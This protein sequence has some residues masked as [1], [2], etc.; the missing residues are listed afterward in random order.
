VE[1]FTLAVCNDP[2][3]VRVVLHQVVLEQDFPRNVQD[4]LN[5]IMQNTVEEALAQALPPGIAF[6]RA[7]EKSGGM[8]AA[9]DEHLDGSTANGE[10][11]HAVA[12]LVDPG[13]ERLPVGEEDTGG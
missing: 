9:G 10:L 4:Q 1:T 8:F 3:V 11:H 12:G 7:L 6:R 13:V 2:D 5:G